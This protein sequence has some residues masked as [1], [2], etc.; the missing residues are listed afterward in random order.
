M[1][2]KTSQISDKSPDYSRRVAQWLKIR[3]TLE[4]EEV[5]KDRGR[6]HLPRPKGMNAEQ[7]RAYKERAVFYG[8]VERTLRGLVGLVFRIDP[9]IEL[10]DRLDELQLR[11]TPDGSPLDTVLRNATREVLSLGRYGLLLDLPQGEVSAAS[12]P[13]IAEYTAENIWRWEERTT[14]GR[15]RVRRIVVRDDT[16]LD[17]S[18]EVTRLRELFLDPDGGDRYTVQIWEERQ[19]EGRSTGIGTTSLADEQETIT[20]TGSF[21][22]IGDPIVPMIQGQALTEIPFVFVNGVD[23]SPTP[24]KPTMLDLANMNL[25]HYRNSADFEHALYLTAQPTPWVIGPADQI[26]KPTSIGSGTF[27]VFPEGTTVGML[28]FTGS[29]IEALEKAMAA[30]ESRMAALGARLIQS[31]PDRSNVTAETTRLQGREETSILIN[32]VKNLEEGVV[33]LLSVAAAW[34]GTDPEEV[35]VALNRDFIEVRLDATEIGSLV[36]GWQAGAFSHQTLWSNLQ[37]GEVADPKRTLEEE[38]QLIEEEIESAPGPRPAAAGP[39]GGGGP[40][41]EETEEVEEAEEEV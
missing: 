12:V 6:T 14:N 31:Q 13:F 40:P 15:R 5:I 29:G 20:E 7:Y 41:P 35:K 28:E 24:S 38:L 36:A 39:F 4:G 10:P 30:K 23:L 18:E 22:K 3:D 25:A 32:G 21:E 34:V 1:A 19:T 37:K 17:G 8:V 33:K 9:T 27:W 11:A 26:E 16:E 2:H